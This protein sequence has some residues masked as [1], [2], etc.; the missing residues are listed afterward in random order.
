VVYNSVP[1][2]H[3]IDTL[4]HIRDLH[5]KVRPSTEEERQ[6]WERRE[7]ATKDLLSNLPRTYEHPTLKTLLQ[8]KDVCSLTLEGAH[9]LFGYNLSAIHDFDLLVNG[10]RTHII[11]DYAFDRDLLVDLPARLAPEV[12]YQSDASLR[13]LVL[14]WQHPTPIRALEGEP[15]RKP[16]SFYVHVG[17]TDSL[18]ASI[19]PGSIALVE[20]IEE[21]E[22]RMPDLGA[23]YLLQFPNGYRC[24]HC[25]T[26]RG[27]LRLFQY[28][29]RVYLGR[30]EYA[31]PGAVRIVGRIRMFALSLPMPEYPSLGPLPESTTGAD[32]ILPWEHRSRDALL[33]TKR[34]RFRRSREE[35]KIIHDFLKHD[36]KTHISQRS[37]RRYRSN[38]LSNPH[39]N[40]LLYLTVDHLARY[41]DTLRTG[42]SWF[43]DFG[44]FSLDV[45]LKARSLEE[46]W[47]LDR[48]ASPPAPAQ[49]WEAR[50]QELGEWPP[51]LSLKFPHLHR[52]DDRVVRLAQ[53]RPIPEIN[54]QI[55]PGSWLLLE[56]VESPPDITRA[57]GFSGWSRPLYALQRGM[58]IICGYLERE[59]NQF[60]L[61]IGSSDPSKTLFSMSEIERLSRVS[62][63]AVP[64]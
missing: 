28:S 8:V 24:S 39:V 15:W 22:R 29:S 26:T 42:H 53:G 56:K 50:R 1:R 58:D 38:S 11:E 43:S 35:N 6:L 62:G 52:W 60:A 34:K 23:I 21:A 33:A 18:G 64:V 49:V 27:K 19:P 63:V 5:R 37:E 7:V 16:G 59:G 55:A 44:R 12:S 54:P 17:T 25:L 31:Y 45:L 36:L 9:R 4:I 51:L 13:E 47:M 32:L 30:Q 14:E 2:S 61:M 3:I 10:S 46:A 20:P 57:K 41:T 40:A 48:Q